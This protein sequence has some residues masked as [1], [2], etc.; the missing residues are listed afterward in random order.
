[1]P[2]ISI[3]TINFNNHAGLRQ[4]IQSVAK[5]T[6]GDF[7]YIVIDGG[8]NDGSIKLLEENSSKITYW[9]SEPDRG[10]YHAMNKGIAKA[11]GEYCLFLNSG[12][13]LAENSTIEKLCMELSGEDIIYGNWYKSFPNGKT[14]PETFPDQITFYFLAFH[15]S[16]PHQATVIRRDLF[17]KIGSYDEGLKMVSDWKFFLDAIFKYHCSYRHID[18]FIAHYDKTGFSSDPKNNELQQRERTKVLET[19]FKNLLYLRHELNG[20]I[21]L[22]RMKNKLKNIIQKFTR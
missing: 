14:E 15:Y 22:F 7:E 9:V 20:S 8:S 12:D 19:E 5:Q 2:K 3:I 11:T 21:F 4:T 6:S 13:C 10:I 1:M 18:L 17:D 16:L